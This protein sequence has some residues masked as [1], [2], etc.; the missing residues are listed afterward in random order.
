VVINSKKGKNGGDKQGT[1]WV[2]SRLLVVKTKGLGGG[3][4]PNKREKKNNR[5][6]EKKKRGKKI[7]GSG[8]TGKMRAK[9]RSKRG[10]REQDG[11][12]WMETQVTWEGGGRG[13]VRGGRSNKWKFTSKSSRKPKQK[14]KGKKKEKLKRAQAELGGKKSWAGRGE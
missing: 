3:R 13:E 10:R 2:E 1:C 14:V 12:E 8:K 4:S 5:K 7:H 6:G 9:G 11:T